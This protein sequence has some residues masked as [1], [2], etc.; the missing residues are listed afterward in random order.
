MG[1]ELVA[2]SAARAKGPSATSSR[3]GRAA[4]DGEDA[5]EA[6]RARCDETLFELARRHAPRDGAT[7]TIAFPLTVER[8]RARFSSWYE[9][10]PRSAS[11][12]RRARHVRRRGGAPGRDRGHGFQRGV[13]A[14]IHPI[15]REKRKGKN[16]VPLSEK[17]TWEPWGIGRRR[18]PHRDPSGAGHA[19][20]FKHL[21][22]GAKL[23]N[24][25]IAMDIASR[26]ARTSRG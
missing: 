7:E 13:P 8:E 24:M 20:D 21:V 14:P 18:R 6:A 2:R 15:G 23:R 5:G 1:A 11:T 10:F 17:A 16:N 9:L 12:A 22:R 3:A 26:S 25:E 4:P 19:V